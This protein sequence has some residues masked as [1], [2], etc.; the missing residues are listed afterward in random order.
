MASPPGN[1]KND[2]AIVQR[3][4]IVYTVHKMISIQMDSVHMET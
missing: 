3:R 4:A 2:A 1:L